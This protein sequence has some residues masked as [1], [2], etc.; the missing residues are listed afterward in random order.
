MPSG[1]VWPTVDTGPLWQEYTRILQQAQLA[2]EQRTP[3][4]ETQDQAALAYLYVMTGGVQAP[5]AAV[6]AYDQYRDAYL[7][8]KQ[9][10]TARSIAAQ[11]SSDPAVK[12]QFATDQPSLQAAVD[13]ALTAW[14]TAGC[15][16]PVEEARRTEQSL[17]ALSPAT[18]WS[19]WTQ[20][21]DPDVVAQTDLE[22]GQF[23]PTAFAP[24]SV[25]DGGLWQQFT[26]GGTEVAQLVQ[27][28]PAQLAARLGAGDSVDVASVD[29][30]ARR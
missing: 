30:S 17:G 13:A 22:G 5:S 23:M 1:P 26:L 11:S 14:E 12:S 19:Q 3:D 15:K 24:S 25:I 4:E 6:V 21:C 10:Y 20:N 16:A 18:T 2:N 7:N 8:A 9:Q 27:G 29:F 28:A